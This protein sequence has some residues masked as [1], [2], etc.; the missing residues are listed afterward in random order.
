VARRRPDL[1]ILDLR[2]PHMSGFDVI[3][4]LHGNP[5]TA[6]IPIMIVT[7]ETLSQDEMVRLSRL[8]VIY[9]PD[10]DSFGARTFLET[11]QENLAPQNGDY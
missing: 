11:V 10:I 3:T 4:E 8:R 7:G 5:E 9:K 6:N 1:I 2:M